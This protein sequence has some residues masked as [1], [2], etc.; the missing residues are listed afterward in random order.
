MIC[1]FIIL[2]SEKRMDKCGFLLFNKGN[3]SQEWKFIDELDKW[4][5]FETIVAKCIF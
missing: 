3:A 5:L 2:L 1:I 4:E